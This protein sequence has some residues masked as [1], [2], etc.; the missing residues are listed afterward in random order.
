[1]FRIEEGGTKMHS[2]ASVHLSGMCVL[3]RSSKT[4]FGGLLRRERSSMGNSHFWYLRD[5]GVGS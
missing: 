5:F 3:S 1:M 2:F 4:L